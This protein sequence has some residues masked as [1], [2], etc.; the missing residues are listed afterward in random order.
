MFD[1]IFNL[2]FEKKAKVK[3]ITILKNRNLNVEKLAIIKK[4]DKQE[5]LT[6]LSSYFKNRKGLNVSERE[7][8]YGAI[9]SARNPQ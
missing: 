9:F 5:E 2:L 7:E 1:K 8:F 3:C 6:C 4:E